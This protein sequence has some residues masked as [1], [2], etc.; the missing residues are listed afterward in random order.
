MKEADVPPLASR[1]VKAVAFSAT[2]AD[3]RKG[4][5]VASGTAG[6]STAWRCEADAC[7]KAAKPTKAGGW[8]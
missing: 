1:T 7:A 8:R 4:A 5:L 2:K 6:Y 3:Y